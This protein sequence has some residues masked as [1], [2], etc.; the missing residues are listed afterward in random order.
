M[1]HECVTHHNACDC[2]EAEHQYQ[3][4]KRDR[5]IKAMQNALQL[6]SR[7][8]ANG[9]VKSKPIISMDNNAASCEMQSLSEIVNAALKT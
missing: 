6:V 1:T 3:I 2:Q 7:G 4:E 8:L 5:K 9:S